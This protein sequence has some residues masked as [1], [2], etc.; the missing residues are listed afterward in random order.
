MRIR[1]KRIYLPPAP[2][3]GIRILVERLWPRGLSKEA[4]QIDLWL[5]E[6]TPSS[7]LRQWFH[8]DPD[9]WSAFKTRYFAELNAN[10]AALTPL[11]EL[12]D[13]VRVTFL[14][15]AREERFNNA[16]ALKEY[17]EIPG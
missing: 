14:F 7:Q 6:A 2:D 5:K 11:Q 15:A 1:L 17:V 3:D 16:V 10:P 4:A 13:A 8:H 12:E 9:L